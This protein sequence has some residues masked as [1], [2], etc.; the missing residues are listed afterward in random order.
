MILIIKNLNKLLKNINQNV[1]LILQLSIHVDRS[2]D[3]PYQFIHSNIL[4][5][6]NILE[7]IKENNKINKKIKLIHI[8]TDEVYGDIKKNKSNEN[9]RTILALRIL[10]QK[11]VQII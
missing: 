7:V 6:F 9:F 11:L 10:L 8:S 4:G 2:I 5:V 1:F 3:S